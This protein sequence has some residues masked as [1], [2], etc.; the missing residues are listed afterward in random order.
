MFPTVTIVN[1]SAFAR[2]N[3][4][5]LLSTIG[6]HTG[7][8][9]IVSSGLAATVANK[10]SSTNA[11]G[12]RTV[13][14]KLKMRPRRIHIIIPLPGGVRRVAHAVHRRVRCG[15]IS[16]VVPHERYVRA[17]GHGLERGG[18]SGT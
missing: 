8:A 2:S 9:I 3:V 16:I 18:T 1:S 15:K 5:N 11:G 13:Y 17:L 14:L 6:S 12:F 4:A 10:R 7:V